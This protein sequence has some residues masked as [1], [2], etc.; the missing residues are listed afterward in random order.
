MRVPVDSFM[1]EQHKGN[2]FI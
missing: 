1:L 2:G